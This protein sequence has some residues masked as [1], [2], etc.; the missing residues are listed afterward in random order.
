[1][2]E[3][4]FGSMAL[5]IE[6]VRFISP[7][8]EPVSELA[9]GGGLTLELC[10]NAHER[11]RSP[12]FTVTLDTFEGETVAEFSTASLAAGT[13][14]LDGRGT[15]A[16]DLERLDLAPGEYYV[17]VGAYPVDWGHTY[18]YHWRAHR[19]RV[20][21]SPRVKGVLLPPHRWRIG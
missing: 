20:T 4:R 7:A 15:I 19:L 1:L 14:A 12:Q 2:N 5:E 11:V 13:P 17:E 9:T 3:N 18:D 16:L 10:Y 6:D 8:R 21:G